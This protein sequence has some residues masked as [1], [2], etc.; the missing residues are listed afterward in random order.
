MC[1]PFGM[2]TLLDKTLS[3]LR[4]TNES[5]SS[6]SHR[7]NVGQRWLRRLMAGDYADPGVNK[8]ERLLYCMENPDA[9][10]SKKE[11]A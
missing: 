4:E 6:I 5:V 3:L 9:D 2:Q 11:A 10:Y 7:A 8:I 1:N